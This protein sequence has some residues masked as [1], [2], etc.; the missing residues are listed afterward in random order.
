MLNTYFIE[1]DFIYD[2]PFIYHVFIEHVTYKM[3][4]NEKPS[5]EA[6]EYKN[7][8]SECAL[9]EKCHGP[10]YLLC[11]LNSSK[12]FQLSAARSRRCCHIQQVDVPGSVWPAGYLR[13]AAPGPLGGGPEPEPRAQV[14]LSLPSCWLLAQQQWILKS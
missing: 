14:C 4:L 6:L 8:N 2:I 7:C 9:L 13:E 10:F 1:M 12:S 11:I 5:T 3:H